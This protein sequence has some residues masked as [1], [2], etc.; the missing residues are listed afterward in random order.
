MWI[1]YGSMWEWYVYI[2]PTHFHIVRGAPEW[3]GEVSGGERL[4]PVGPGVMFIDTLYNGHRKRKYKLLTV[5][6]IYRL[7]SHVCHPINRTTC[8]AIK[9]LTM[10]ASHLRFTIP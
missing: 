8:Y 1:R 7:M 9:T 2:P 3:S 10:F 6:N 4:G 5:Y